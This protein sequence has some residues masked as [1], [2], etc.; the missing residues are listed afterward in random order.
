M[1]CRES[2][3]ID[4]FVAGRLTADG[5][6]GLEAHLEVCADCFESFA[7]K[8]A[9]APEQPGPIADGR[10][11]PSERMKSLL[12]SRDI[13][14]SLLPQRDDAGLVRHSTAAS[15]GPYLITGLLGQGGMGVVFRARHRDS[16][17][18]VALK[19]VKA[20]KL[21]SF[22]ALRQ[23]IEFLREARHPGI[24]EVLDY[25]LSAGDPWYAMELLEGTTLEGWNTEIWRNVDPNGLRPVAAGQLVAVLRLYAA[26]CEPLAFV[27]SHGIVHCDL[28]PSNVFMRHELRPVLMDFGLVTRARGMIGREALAVSGPL[29]G[30]LPYMAPETLR[31]EMPD[32][33]ADVY[34]LGCMLYESLSGRPPFVADTPARLGEMHRVTQPQP[35]SSLVSGVPSSLD[36]L[37]GRALAKNRVD[38]IGHAVDVGSW[39]ADILSEVNPSPTGQRYAH[40]S[41]TSQTHLF[42][43]PLAGRDGDLA[44]L[45]KHVS[46]RSQPGALILISGESGIGKTFLATE[47]AQQAASSGMRVVIGE[48]TP[49]APTTAG[50]AA[51]GSAPLLP[52][53]RLFELIGDHCRQAGPS[54][55]E[56]LLGPHLGLLASFFPSLGQLGPT[57]V[58]S[59]LPAMAARERVIRTVTDVL[60]AFAARRRL[61]I[62]LDD[63]QWADDLTMAVLQALDRDYLRRVPVVLLG[64]YRTDERTESLVALA[65]RRDVISC[66][67]GRLT[68][69]SMRHL[70]AGMLGMVT[71]PAALIQYV[72]EQAEGIPFFAG[73]YLRALVHDGL[74]VRKHGS[75]SLRDG[76]EARKEDIRTALPEKLGELI[77]HRLANLSEDAARVIR[78]A[79]VAG[80]TFTSALL[81]S[82]TARSIDDV[83]RDLLPSAASLIIVASPHGYRFAHDKLRENLYAS[84]T[85]DERAGLHLSVARALDQRLNDLPAPENAYGQ[86]AFHFQQ[87]GDAVRAIDYLEKAGEQAMAMAAHA[88]AL[89]FFHEAFELEASLPERVAGLRRARWERHA[90]EAWLGLGKMIESAAALHRAARLLGRPL[91][92][93]ALAFS[94]TA[95]VELVRQIVHARRSDRQLDP[96]PEHPARREAARV[97]DRLLQV[98]YFLGRER[99]AGLSILLALN[100][101][102][103]LPPT[104]ESASIYSSAAI[105]AG[106]MP[107]PRITEHYFSLAERVLAQSPDDTAETWLRL[108]AGVYYLG[109]GQREKS[110]RHLER[111]FEVARRLGYF[112]RMDE[113]RSVRANVEILA[114]HHTRA[115]MY[116]R[117]MEAESARRN[118]L[119]M[120]G[121]ALLLQID[122]L[123]MQRL[124]VP[125]ALLERA[126]SL[127]A[128][129]SRPDQAW[130]A[131]VDA[132]ASWREGDMSGALDHLEVAIQHASAGRP[133][134]LACVT[135]F[136]RIVE[137][138]LDLHLRTPD[139]A[140][141]RRVVRGSS[142][143]LERMA[144]VFPVARPMLA[145]H[146]GTLLRAVNKPRRAI[147]AWLGGIRPARMMGL[148]HH[149]ARL[150]EA[151]AAAH[152]EARRAKAL[153]GRLAEKLAR[154]LTEPTI[155]PFVHHAP[156][157][158]P[159]QQR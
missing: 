16:G 107:A 15:I 9:Q 126:R 82:V 38:R 19:T 22:A 45:T 21:A 117:D 63:L 102:A 155:P 100:L 53:Q 31:S 144:G 73:E 68:V 54:E 33:R 110:I 28:K 124:E 3:F 62:A 77:A 81:A 151:L 156:N 67:L 43:P 123:I 119:H 86:I 85:N 157:E 2:E 111:A 32:A 116:L 51:A 140:R 105:M 64:T 76:P 131:S 55:T 94:A 143:V 57:S 12:A 30:T 133:V 14:R 96:L 91:P 4:A 130:M 60:A 146:Q 152:P 118:D 66:E 34:A 50:G 56:A 103:Q 11:G 104:H 20:P 101:S 49:R 71:P 61:L 98:S 35:V 154:S 150:H 129:M 58:P 70:V 149:E 13:T 17:R 72:H 93:N 138:A 1:G 108:Q 136:G 84:V 142:R 95:A 135:A 23:E 97:F 10:T 120:L 141:I 125:P 25:D 42:R 46:A 137:L 145:L 99:D 47:V 114:G 87:G 26:L 115:A 40:R 7:Q 112:R 27:H 39:L 6:L 121:W 153:H 92:R 90:A 5:V 8:L 24:V 113:V 69:E 139:D 122:S 134:H 80:R 159:S 127:R 29:R 48:C 109:R 41:G 37:L 36:A 158:G 78:A 132:Y 128:G 75:W 74:L 44:L 18:P 52:F 88:D 106:V 89:R 65:S 83:E 59:P 79:A 148:P 147:A